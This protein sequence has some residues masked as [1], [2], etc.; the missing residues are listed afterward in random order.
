MTLAALRLSSGTPTSARS[1]SIQ[2]A[3]FPSSTVV[4]VA[5]ITEATITDFNR[6]IV[7]KNSDLPLANRF[8]DDS[9]TEKMLGAIV[10]SPT[11]AQAADALLQCPP[12][13]RDARFYT[14]PVWL[15]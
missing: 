1:S 11:L 3:C 8:S 15:L 4:T 7:K 13:N 2:M 12:G 9:M 6:L 10:T 14:Q 5:G